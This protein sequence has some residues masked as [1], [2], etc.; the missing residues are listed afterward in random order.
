[1]QVIEKFLSP[2]G[3]VRFPRINKEVL[4]CQI[5]QEATPYLLEDGIYWCNPRYL[6]ALQ[7]HDY[8]APYFI[9]SS[10]TFAKEGVQ[11]GYKVQEL[12]ILQPGKDEVRAKLKIYGIKNHDYLS[13]IIVRTSPHKE[14]LIM[15]LRNPFYISPKPINKKTLGLSLNFGIRSFLWSDLLKAANKRLVS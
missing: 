13:K 10:H 7:A 9:K 5:K 2:D 3:K 4:I 8:F 15:K 11:Y 1:M 12:E 6:K 14:I